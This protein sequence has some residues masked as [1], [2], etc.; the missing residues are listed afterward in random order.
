MAGD[1]HENIHNAAA[2]GREKSLGPQHPDVAKGLCN[3]ADFYHERGRE[4]GAES[5]YL[6]ALAILQ[7]SLAH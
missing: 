2:P 6:R 7:K 5:L 1:R 3:L 4:S